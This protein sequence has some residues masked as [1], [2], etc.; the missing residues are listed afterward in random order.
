[1]EVMVSLPFL[2]QFIDFLL[3]GLKHVIRD[4]K[5][6]VWP[7]YRKQQNAVCA[8]QFHVSRLPIFGT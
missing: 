8:W 3:P 2:L 1:M 6:E 5:I 7:L 4:L